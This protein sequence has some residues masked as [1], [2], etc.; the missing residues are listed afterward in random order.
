MSTAQLTSCRFP[1]VVADRLESFPSRALLEV[2]R[3]H[4]SLGHG[5][6]LKHAGHSAFSDMH[7]SCLESNEVCVMIHGV[8]G[9]T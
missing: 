8:E 2:E 9:N 7:C 6:S 4:I 3:H 1:F 5:E